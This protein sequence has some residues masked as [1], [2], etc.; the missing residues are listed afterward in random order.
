MLYV[1]IKLIGELVAVAMA[2]FI[3]TEEYT[4]GR[5]FHLYSR[6]L[7]SDLLVSVQ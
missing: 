3:C 2:G 7:Y 6:Y 1:D 5:V 4:L